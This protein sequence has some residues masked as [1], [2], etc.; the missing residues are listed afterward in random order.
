M[1][2]TMQIWESVNKNLEGSKNLGLGTKICGL[3][4]KV[5]RLGMKIWGLGMKFWGQWLKIGLTD[6]YWCIAWC[7]TT[8]AER[9]TCRTGLCNHCQVPIYT[10][11]ESGPIAEGIEFAGN[12]AAVC[13]HLAPRVVSA[14]GPRCTQNR[15]R[16]QRTVHKIRK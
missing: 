11:I 10:H 12:L 2:T 16:T 7:T 8:V 14:R 3:K 15:L 1:A 9:T 6:M 4:I 13:L 5:W